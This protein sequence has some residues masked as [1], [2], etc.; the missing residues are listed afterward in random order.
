MFTNIKN[1]VV[2]IVPEYR[3]MKIKKKLRVNPF[4]NVLNTEQVRSY[5]NTSKIIYN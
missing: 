3:F 1:I 5:L 2:D 4:I